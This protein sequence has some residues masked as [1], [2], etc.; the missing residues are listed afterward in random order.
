MFFFG[1]FKNGHELV[2]LHLSILLHEMIEKG[3][4]PND[5]ADSCLIDCLCKEEKSLWLQLAV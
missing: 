5:I 1:F 2:R 4:A 3:I